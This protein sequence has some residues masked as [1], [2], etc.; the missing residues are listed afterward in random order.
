MISPREAER[1]ARQI[2]I[3]GSEG[4][5]CLGQA[6]VLV[7]GAG[8]L[9]SA[10]SIYLCAA[11]VGSIRLVDRDIIE[12]SNLNRQ[13]FHWE[14]DIGRKKT[15]SA[16]EKLEAMNPDVN[17]E[18]IGTE[19]TESN[20]TGLL[21]GVDIV[22]DALDNF[23]TR[24]LLNH[25]ILDAGIPLVH[26]AVQGF[27]GQV[28]TVVPG[29]T[30]CLRCLFPFAPPPERIPVIGTTPG[31]IGTIQANE[32]LKFLIREGELL[33]SRLLFWDGFVNGIEV[34][35]IEKNLRCMECGSEEYE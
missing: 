28:T 34:I 33:E 6:R 11:G 2:L 18:A 10:V 7:A 29:K 4:Q 23:P 32:V 24:Y 17:I 26:G 30:P 1:Y 9:G 27:H 13:V 25:A 8:G 22:V 19:I 5:E 15:E 31:I 14:R 21:D 35:A 12:R 20:I 16:K 3:F